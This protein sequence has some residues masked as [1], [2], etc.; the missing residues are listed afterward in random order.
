MFPSSARR[1]VLSYALLCGCWIFTTPPFS[2][3]DEWSHYLRALGVGEGRL[4]GAR[5]ES[6]RDAALA[7]RQEAWVAQTVRWTE[8]RPGMSPE[9]YGCNALQPAQSAACLY[10]VP[11]PP[12]DVMRMRTV[13]GTYQPAGYLLPAV[14]LFGATGPVSG[15]FRARVAN[16]LASLALIVLSSAALWP[17]LLGFVIAVTPMCLFLA[18][19]L[20]P[21]GLEITGAIAF[22]SGLV[23]L[24]RR[25]VRPWPW[26]AAVLG[27]AALCLSRSLGPAFLAILAAVWVAWLGPGRAWESVR[28]SP[29]AALPGSAVLAL[30]VVANRAWEAAYGP[31]LPARDESLAVALRESV[32]RVPGWI[33]EQIGIF[34]Y[35]DAPM[36]RFAYVLWGALVLVLVVG[37]GWVGTRR[38]RLALAASVAAAIAVPLALHALA[39]RPIG[40]VVQGRHVLPLTVAVPILSA[41]IVAAR[42]RTVAAWAGSAVAAL[43]GLVHFLALYSNGRR[44]AVGARGSWLFPLAP[45]WSPTLG[46]LPW[47]LLA[48]MACVLLGTVRPSPCAAFRA[49]AGE[50]RVEGRGP[51]L[52]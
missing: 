51:I 48:A 46:W 5:V 14:A 29:R 35:L 32:R 36:P 31:H 45:E 10:R 19:T 12:R 21:S 22:V 33:R 13:N 26:A 52:P 27:G 23:G 47:L 43:A 9:G 18:S 38:D 25:D 34:Q 6:F 39:M 50:H 37:A 42:T 16:A 1:L 30:A 8:V 49:H 44:S 7:P 24:A 15:I 3:P 20:N 40:W 11:P 17:N 2:A 41:E 28:R 4:V